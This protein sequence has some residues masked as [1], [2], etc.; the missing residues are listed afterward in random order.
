[1]SILK[2]LELKVSY[3][4]GV[5]DILRD[6]YIPCLKHSKLYYRGVGYFTSDSLCKAAEG[7]EVFVENG[8]TIK[9]VACPVLNQEDK[10]AILHGYELREERLKAF[11]DKITPILIS[12]IQKMSENNKHHLEVLSW[13]IAEQKLDIKLAL[14]DDGIYHEKFGVFFE[15]EKVTSYKVGF[16]G[17]SNETAGGLIHNF[18]RIS[19]FEEKDQREKQRIHEFVEDFALLW[20]NYTGGLDVVSLPEEAKAIIVRHKPDKPPTNIRRKPRDL[21]GYQNDA[22]RKWKSNNYCGILSMVTGSGKTY[23]ALMAV[24]P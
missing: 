3:R 21:R 9:L 11:S 13:L 18:E 4:T 6:F 14:R 16:I 22:I 23:T 12:E 20:D 2:D 24:K 15:E 10:D 19:I 5:D 17:S 7:L 1:M 8:G